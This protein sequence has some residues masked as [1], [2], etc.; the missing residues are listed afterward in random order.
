MAALTSNRDLSDLYM[1]KKFYKT[2]LK[3][4]IKQKS[5]MHTLTKGKHE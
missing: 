4:F 3:L 1:G 5:K 2:H